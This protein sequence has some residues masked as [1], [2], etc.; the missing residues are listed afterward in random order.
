MSARQVAQVGLLVAVVAVVAAAP[1]VGAVGTTEV[2]TL[3]EN[4]TANESSASLGAQIS[5]FMQ[6]SSAE[7]NGS[8]DD[9]MWV[10]SFNSTNESDRERVVNGRVASIERRLDRLQDRLEALENA[11]ENGTIPEVAYVAQASRLNEQIDALTDSINETDEAARRVGVND[12]RLDRL[13]TEASNMTG[14]EIARLARNLSV[15]GP[16]AGAGPP[17][18]AGPPEDAGPDD[19]ETGPP[20]DPGPP[21]DASPDGNETGRPEDAGPDDDE[22][23]P[24]DDAGNGN[25]GGPPDDSGNGNDGG[26][27]DDAGGGQG[28]SDSTD[29]ADDDSDDNDSDD[30]SRSDGGNAGGGNSGGGNSGG[31]NPGGGPR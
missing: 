27:P 8:V 11:R 14:H 25:D 26:P 16:P 17:D 18:D 9:G 31:G 23:G 15:V 29:D 10:A 20:E 5:S 4:G 22:T 21:D 28:P 24:P 2:T 30:G 19:D 6:A 1:A 3:P 12:T 7:A 13:R